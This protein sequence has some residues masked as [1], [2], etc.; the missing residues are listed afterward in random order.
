MTVNPNTVI[1]LTEIRKDY[2]NLSIGIQGIGTFERSE[3]RH[4]IEQLDN[5][6][7]I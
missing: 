3:L 2:Y 4:M 6:V 5:K 1:T 7:S